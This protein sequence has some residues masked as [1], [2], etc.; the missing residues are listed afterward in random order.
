M[1]ATLKALLV[2]ATA[3]LSLALALGAWRAAESQQAGEARAL[4][5]FRAREIAL[6]LGG[7]MYDY[8]QVLRGTV[9]LLAASRQVTA[10]EW[11]T[12]V[13]TL[14]L[15]STYPGIQALAYAAR[16]R[17]GGRETAV[18]RYI[19]PRVRG[20]ERVPG[21]DLLSEPERRR[22]IER[23]RD[24]GE[25]VLTG[26]LTLL[27]E[28]S[29][30]SQ[31][32]FVMFL[33]VYRGGGAPA[34]FAER[35]ARFAAVVYAAFRAPDLFRGTIG[36]PL[37]LH[38]RLFDATDPASPQL[39][40]EDARDAGQPRYERA[41]PLVVRGRTW[42]LEATSQ[43]AFEAL[44]IGDRARVVLSGGIALSV[45]LTALVWSLVNT[46]EQARALA[47][48]MVVAGE[49]RDR[50]RSAVDHH[51]DIM[52][53][54]D[55]ARMRFV[56]ANEGACRSL[57]YRREELIGHSAALV[58]ADRDEQQLARQY[59]QLAAAELSEIERGSFRRKDGSTLPVEISRQLL[60]TASGKYVLGVARDITA[61]LEAERSLRDSEARLAL[62]LESS[63]LALFDW[64]L[65]S[66]LV[67]LGKEW[68]VLL[69]GEAEA[70]VTPIQKLEQLV[71][72]DDLPMVRAQ[73][74]KLLAGESD[75][76]RI[77]HRVRTLSGQ[78]KWIESVA[79]VSGRDAAGRATRVTGTN[80]DIG[81][82]KA[83]ADLKSAFIAN[84]S[85]ELRTPLTGIVTSLGLLQEG[86]AGELPEQAR[87][88]VDIA[89][90]NSE[91]LS[92]LINDILDLER[93]ETGRLRLEMRPVAVGE[94]LSKVA[95][96]NAPYA[97]RYKA[98]IVTRPPGRELR[99]MA[100]DD[101]LLQVLTNL[102]SNAAKHSPPD[103]EIA[104][105]AEVKD[106]RVIFSVADCGPGI[107]EEFKPRVFG[108]FEQADAGKSGT[109][110][111][112]AISKAL[113]EKMGG[114]I[115]F[116]SVPGRGATFYVELPIAR[117]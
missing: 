55:V 112:L 40:Y 114:E 94:L 8:E 86:S 22:A 97:E 49:E 96:L 91:R 93:V 60:Q 14:Q 95:S 98:R 6:A 111:G 32:S 51:W 20:N 59:E 36:Q 73:L 71:H 10:R 101:R 68:R 82:R 50:F 69:G 12:Y 105:A 115:R 90:G 104:L 89:Y 87:R 62:A 1:G 34:S 28:P 61:R 117:L 2:A 80:A 15:D 99:V 79:R 42:R 107:A 18:V 24:T 110:L 100:D 52:L 31:P 65:Q 113:V 44:N 33:P 30:S 74:R 3:A 16:G 56:Y 43:P 37:G 70:T 85:H 21:F 103:G 102:V 11:K 46:R 26:K 29:G 63:G 58:F 13:S 41:E 39:L 106:G 4:F 78:W 54:V 88:F 53:M 67:H 35:R 27:S 92:A 84:V 81:A 57:G 19:E 5:E 83:V 45:L 47:R 76:Y 64:D 23:A 7:R 108:K 66:N 72:A 77:E 38:L 109:G 75:G 25:A 17:D 9:G 48:S 116:A